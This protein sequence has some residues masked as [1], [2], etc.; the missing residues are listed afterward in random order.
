ARPVA[1]S[2][3][4]ITEWIDRPPAEPLSAIDRGKPVDLSLKTLDPDDA[5]R[6]AAYTEDLLHTRTH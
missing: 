6:L 2:V 1:R 3:R 5:A 4:P